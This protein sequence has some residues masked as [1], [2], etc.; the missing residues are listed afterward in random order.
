MN[1][2]K[3]TRQPGAE[4]L[5]IVES[6]LAHLFR[7]VLILVVFATTTAMA[8]SP[9]PSS[10]PKEALSFHGQ[11]GELLERYV[12]NG[13]VDY[14]AWAS[15]QD[16]A[17]A[18]DTYIKDLTALNPPDWPRE[19]GLAY[20]I[21]L[22]NAVTVDLI[23]ENYPLE[24][25]KDIGGFLRKSP[26]K[27]ELVSVGGRKLT[28]NDI[29]NEIIRPTFQDPRIHF[30]LNCASIGCPTLQPWPFLP[31]RL[32][33]DLDRACREAM[34]G[35]RWVRPTPEGVELTRIFDWYKG[36]FSQSGVIAFINRYRVGNEIDAN[37]K[38]S[39][40]AYDWSL[41]RVGSRLRR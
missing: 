9:A 26:W 28:L 13:G 7:I 24:S 3:L 33:D 18:L 23:L 32:D 39:Y 12:R 37:A 40:L 1:R 17:S 41:N 21:N 14:A 35:E 34:N 4:D 11:Y 2:S 6:S 27:R 8:P 10:N 5:L 38:I 36:D 31:S 20:W 16:D 19:D 29:E 15:N 22:Y 25:I 30:A